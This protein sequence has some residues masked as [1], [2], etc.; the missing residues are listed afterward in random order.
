M[1]AICFTGHR[2]ILED[3]EVLSQHLYK[4]LE[5]AVKSALP[6]FTPEVRSAGIRLRH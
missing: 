5:N 2:D 4:R 6:T 1:A 3:K